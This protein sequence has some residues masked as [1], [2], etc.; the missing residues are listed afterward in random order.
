MNVNKRFPAGPGINLRFLCFFIFG[1][2][3]LF[4]V[5]LLPALDILLRPKGVFF[6]PLG[7]GNRTSGGGAR[8]FPG[9][10]ADLGLEIDLASIWSNRIGL[11]YTAGLEGG[12]LIN[13]TKGSGSGSV[14]VYSLGGVFGLYY[15]PLSRLF[16]RLDTAIGVYQ[17]ARKGSSGKPGFFFRGGLEAGYRFTPVFTLAGNLGWRHYPSGSSGTLNSGLYAGLTAQVTFRTGAAPAGG[18]S[19]DFDQYESVYPVFM[20]LYQNSPIGS[21]LI[22]NNE[23]AEIRDVYLGFRAPGYTAAE[24]LCGSV[25]LIQ[26]SRSAQLQVFADFSPAMLRFTDRGGISG[27]FVIRYTLLGRDRETIIPVAMETLSRNTVTVTD[28]AALAALVTPASP[29]IVNYANHIA[30]IARTNRPAGHNPN[31]HYAICLVEGLRTSGIHLAASRTPDNEAQFPSETLAYGAGSNRDLGLLLAAC[32]ESAGVS[33]AYLKTDDDFITAFSLGIDQAA[34]ET[35]F[36][37]FER[38]LVIDDE[39]WLPLSMNAL[40]EGFMASWTRGAETLSGVFSA[41]GGLDFII[42]GQAWKIYPPAPLPEQGGRVMRTDTTAL[43]AGVNRAVQQYINQEIIPLVNRVQLQINAGPA[44]SLYNR[45][46]ILSVRA[47]RMG[48]GRT[49]YEMAAGMGSV[50]AMTNRGGLAL[51][52]RDYDAASYWFTKAL[53]NDNR[54]S[55]ALRGLELIEERR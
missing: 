29:E 55:A 23:N 2:L 5:S 49:N 19:A 39:V 14:S 13:A 37:S 24:Y 31:M 34:S 22:T 10:G 20:R 6:A 51:A 47:G 36:S 1:F 25:P 8:Y 52:E 16:T 38:I 33:S 30:G 3:F 46:G 40:N 15:Y 18:T 32:L 26:R 42:T 48:E 44:P 54:N 4:N 41:E 28:S 21:V 27:E 53:E 9:G 7:S 45:L 43:S 17:P 35:L 12:L 50:A 11:G